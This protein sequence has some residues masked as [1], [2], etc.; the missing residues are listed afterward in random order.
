MTRQLQNELENIKKRLLR[1]SACVE[2]SVGNAVL[3]VS[4]SDDKLANEIIENDHSINLTEIEIEE[5]CLKILALH[6]PVAIDLRV[7]IAILK[8]NNDLERVA[9]I[10]VNIA[11]RSI[12][13]R[14]YKPVSMPFDFEEMAGETRSMLKRSLDAFI[15][16]DTTLAHQVSLD[17][18]KI[19]TIHRKM[20]SEVF[21]QIRK[22]PDNVEPLISSFSISRCLERIADYATNIAEDVIY[23]VDGEI[24]RHKH[25]TPT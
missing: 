6:Q 3:S 19:D 22:N 1:L 25:G 11:K 16:Q 23:M 20:H 15:E 12:Y 14:R 10:A 5:E 2:E 8:I 4:E 21:E 18:D 9:D 17:D 24:I 13:L 7:L